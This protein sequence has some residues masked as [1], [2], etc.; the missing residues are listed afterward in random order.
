MGRYSIPV[1]MFAVGYI[2][3]AAVASFFPVSVPVDAVSMNWSV[4]VFGGVLCIACVDYVF[5]GRKHYVAPVQHV[6]K[7]RD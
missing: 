1:N 2:I 5:R 4:V 3:T 7:E 6:E